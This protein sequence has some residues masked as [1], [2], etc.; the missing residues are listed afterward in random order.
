M[1]TFF[2]HLLQTS[3]I[4]LLLYGVYVVALQGDTFFHRNRVYLLLATLVA[5]LLPCVPALPALQALQAHVHAG[6]FQLLIDETFAPS[7]TPQ[8]TLTIPAVASIAVGNAPQNSTAMYWNW[9]AA[10]YGLGVLVAAF[11]FLKG[12][13]HILR[14]VAKY[15]LQT[16]PYAGV[17]QVKL[18]KHLPVF[19]FLNI[20]FWNENEA[21]SP[22]QR[23]KILLHELTHI[24]Q[25]HTLDLLLMEVLQ[26]IFW[27]NP[28]AYWAKQSLQALHEYLADRQAVN[29]LQLTDATKDSQNSLQNKAIHCR[30]YAKLLV[31]QTFQ[32]EVYALAHSFF[33]KSLLKKR[34]MMLQK[35]QTNRRALWKML[36]ILPAL[37]GGLFLVACSKEIYKLQTSEIEAQKQIMQTEFEYK[38][39]KTLLPNS[40]NQVSFFAQDHLQYGIS[41]VATDNDYQGLTVRIFD[42]TTKKFS[43]DYEITKP[44]FLLFYRKQKD[45]NPE[46]M[47]EVLKN[48]KRAK[49]VVVLVGEYDM[50]KHETPPSPPQAGSLQLSAKASPDAAEITMTLRNDMDYSFEVT[51]G[52]AKLLFK[53]TFGT[54]YTPD[55]QGI[56][57]ISPVKDIGG[58]LQIAAEKDATV[59]MRYT[60]R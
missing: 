34:I 16:S 31:N 21:L 18:P 1:E 33:K 4:W 25:L 24:K 42:E 35:Q 28:V 57:R 19:T 2:N 56:V 26:I 52:K 47:M 10:I 27:F 50:S 29:T 11:R 39:I 43:E 45:N 37:V 36:G 41:F 5:L 59:T 32:G 8:P 15:G 17:Y 20:L 6:E 23:R 55:K 53:E 58:Y 13:G 9:L 22:Q 49:N 51:A 46:C 44:K 38:A 12:L 54:D 48:G 3:L 14:L 40:A 60:P 30:E 7:P